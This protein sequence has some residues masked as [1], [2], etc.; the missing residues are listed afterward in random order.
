[1]RKIFIP[2]LLVVLGL[3]AC[4]TGPGGLSESYEILFGGTYDYYYGKDGY[5]TDRDPDF[6]YGWDIDGS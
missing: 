1:M 4:Q 5:N 3:S 6:A 2:A